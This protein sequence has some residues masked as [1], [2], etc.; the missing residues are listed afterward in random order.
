MEVLDINNFLIWKTD[1]STQELDITIINKLNLLFGNLIKKSKK[2]IKKNNVNILKNQKIQNKKDNIDS[3]VNLILN[4]LSELN[5]NSLIIEFIQNINQIDLKH[6]EEIQQIFYVKIISE[7]N[8]VKVYLQFIKI[9]GYLYNKV[10]N[11]DLSFFYSII[12]TKFML[13]YSNYDI[14]PESKFNFLKEHDGEIKRI[15]NLILIKNLVEIKM[16]NITIYDICDQIIINQDICLPDIYYWYSSKNRDLNV[17]EKDK[18]NIYLKKPNINSRETVLLENLINK[19]IVKLSD[20]KQ[21]I[22]IDNKKEPEKININT[23]ELETI[24]IIDEYLLIKSFDD[25]KYFI[26]TRC[27]DAIAKNKFCEYVF[28]RY[29]S[30]NKTNSF[31][32][33]ELILELIKK[34]VLF[35]SNLSRGLLLLNNNWQHKSIDYNKPVDKMKNILSTLK[36]NGITNGLENLLTHYKIA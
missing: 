15:N 11:Y 6:F 20:I 5:I 21:K 13:D 27:I 14:S 3:K 16:L 10:Q 19:K 33:I 18:I 34:K 26:E 25:V 4:K 28:D 35:K 2:N 30:L 1:K 12:E 29:F 22:V 8:F 17:D 7:I 24:N 31:E 23:L 9:L 36:K 32:V